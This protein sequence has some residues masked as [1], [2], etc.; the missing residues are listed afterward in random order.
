MT[1][2]RSARYSAGKAL[3]RTDGIESGADA[4]FRSRSGVG[5]SVV[6]GKGEVCGGAEEKEKEEKNSEV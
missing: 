6:K 5:W 4:G 3:E 1:G 2:N